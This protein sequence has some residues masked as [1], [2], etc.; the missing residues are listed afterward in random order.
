LIFK[1]SYKD[2]NLTQS[3]SLSVRPAMPYYSSFKAGYSEDSK[4]ELSPTRKLFTNMAEQFI[5]ASA[6]PLVLATGLSSYLEAFPHGCTEQVVS[7]VFPLVGLMSHPAYGSQVKDVKIHFNQAISKLRERQRGDGGFV[8]WPGGD[9]TADY[10]TIYA[11]HFLIEARSLGFPV[12]RDMLNRGRSYLHQYAS[13][14]S[15]SLA[16]ARNR[17]NA[18]YLLTRLG[19]VTTNYLVD[20]EEYLIAKHSKTW[21]KDLLSSYM[22]ATYKLLKKDTE[23]SRLITEYQLRDS[24]KGL[25]DF[26]SDLALDAQYIYLLSKHFESKARSL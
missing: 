13:N 2:D 14:K 1:A 23:A 9:S 24:A 22:A 16:T 3:V 8:F 20:L 6:S 21:K 17:A 15:T 19:E 11:M 25:G 26:H 18:I 5:T 12:P 10:P 4:V 7:K